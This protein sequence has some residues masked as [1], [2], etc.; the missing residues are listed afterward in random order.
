MLGLRAGF[1]F[2]Y[3]ILN[4][5][6]VSICKQMGY[7]GGRDLWDSVAVGLPLFVPSFNNSE[8]AGVTIQSYVFDLYGLD[9]QGA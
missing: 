4:G 2:I 6:S 3:F 1:A 8:R 7:T 9:V 5:L